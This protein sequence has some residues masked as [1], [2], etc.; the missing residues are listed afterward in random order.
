MEANGNLYG[1]TSSFGDL[2][3]SSLCGTVFELAVTGVLTVLHTFSGG[4]DGG[5][6]LAG[7][8]M[9]PAGNLYGTTFLGGAFN[10]GVVFGIKL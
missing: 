4:A 7:L 9:D 6:P 8:V 3:C 1:T 2:S 10:H 5:W